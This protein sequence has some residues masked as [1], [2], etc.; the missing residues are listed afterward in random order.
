MTTAPGTVVVNQLIAGI[1][2]TE[3]HRLLANCESVHL[4]FG[5]SLCE[6][7]E[8]LEYVYFPLTSFI[9]LVAELEGHPPLEVCLIGNEGIVGATLALDAEISPLRAIVQGSGMAL[10]IRPEQLR[11]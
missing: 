7:Y 4:L 11:P 10:R 9:S 6:A 5:A 1:P 2:S 8:P 3:S